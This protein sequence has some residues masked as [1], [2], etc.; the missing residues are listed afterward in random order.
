M[1]GHMPQAT[2]ATILAA[3]TAEGQC[4]SEALLQIW[5]TVKLAVRTAYMLHSIWTASQVAHHTSTTQCQPQ[6]SPLP[7]VVQELMLAQLVRS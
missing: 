7:L 2:V 3:C 4:T 6:S 5:H 1:T